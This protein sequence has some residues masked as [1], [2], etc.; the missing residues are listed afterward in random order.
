[1][2][3]I[4]IKLPNSTIKDFPDSSMMLGVGS[5]LIKKQLEPMIGV[6]QSSLKLLYNKDTEVSNFSIKPGID[7]NGGS[8]QSAI[9]IDITGKNE[10]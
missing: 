6:I 2:I 3:S 9:S 7:F 8:G 4:S 1:M 10:N 5:N